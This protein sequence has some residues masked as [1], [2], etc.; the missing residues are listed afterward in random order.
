M[1][2]CRNIWLAVISAALFLLVY[3]PAIELEEQHL[4]DLFPEYAAY[5]AR[6]RRF[7]PLSRWPG[8]QAQFSWSLYL[9][10][11]EYQAAIGF[12]LAVLWLLLKLCM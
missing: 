11:R 12:V 7:L 4:G 2:A 3:F 8:G 5:A 10:N 9:R 6:V 1:I